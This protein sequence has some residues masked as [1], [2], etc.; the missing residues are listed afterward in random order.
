M[1]IY[2]LRNFNV[3]VVEINKVIALVAITLY[4]I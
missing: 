1:K 2:A 4:L 3:F